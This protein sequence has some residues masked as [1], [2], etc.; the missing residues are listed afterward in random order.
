LGKNDFGS[1]DFQIARFGL[2][3][4]GAED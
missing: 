4:G 3:V 1:I 2:K